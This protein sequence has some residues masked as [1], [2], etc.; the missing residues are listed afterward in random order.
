MESL[1]GL[2]VFG[3]DIEKK[4]EKRTEQN[5]AANTFSQICICHR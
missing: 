1:S 5:Q 2:Y 4:K 3:G